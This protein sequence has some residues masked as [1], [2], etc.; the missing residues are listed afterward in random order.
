M[1][2]PNPSADRPADDDAVRSTDTRGHGPRS[3]GVSEDRTSKNIAEW[4]T[5]LP[6]DCV[7]RMV[8]LGW[9]HTT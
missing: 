3:A 2:Y 7:T 6:A 1:N 4:S 8:S 9:G 5:Y